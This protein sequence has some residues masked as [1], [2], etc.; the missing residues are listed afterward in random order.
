M[1]KRV[2]TIVPAVLWAAAGLAVGPMS[3]VAMA[4]ADQTANQP[5]NQQAASRTFVEQPGVLEFTG[6]LI[7]R[8]IQGLVAD[9][10]A[11]ARALLAPM[12]LRHHAAVDEYIVRVPLDRVTAGVAGS[13]ENALA[14]E[15]MATGFFQYAVPNWMCYP[16]EVTPN[17]PLFSSQW[18]HQMMR[19]QAGWTISTGSPDLTVAVTDTGI[20]LTHPDLTSHRVLGYDAFNNIAEVNG[21]SVAD[22]HG[23]GTHV[24][25]CAA[26]IGDNG[27]GVA[28]PNWNSKI[29]MIRV[30]INS[31]GGA[32]YEDLMEGAR[33]AIENGAKTVSASYSGVDY[34]PIQT[35]GA[36]IKS[37]GGLYFYAAGNDAR[38]L[39]MFDWPDVTVVGASES[40]DNR[41]GFSA[42]GPG[43]DVFAP[44]QDILSSING[45]AYGWASGT[46]MAT[47]VANGV[48]SLIWSINPAL[49]PDQVQNLL[50]TSSTDKG[51]PGDDDVWGWGRVDVLGA[52]QA[53]AGTLG[54]ADPTASDDSYIAVGDAVAPEAE[55]LDVLSND[56]D[57]NGDAI[58][59]LSF[60]AST[61]AG[62]TLTRSVGTGPGGRDQIAYAA[63]PGYSGA[64][65]FSYTVQDGT[66]RTDTATVT[67][68][69]MDSS[70]FRT[71]ENPIHRAAEINV[72]YY[73]T[74]GFSNLPNFDTMTPYARARSADINYPSTNGAFA[75]SGRSDEVGA[76]FTGFVTVPRT[77]FYT[78]YTSSDDGSRLL[79]GDQVV[80]N[81]DGLHAMEERSGQ[82]GLKAGT[83]AIRVNFFENGGGAGVIASIQGPGLAKQP[84]AASM[85]SRE[86]CGADFNGDGF[87]DF[88]DYDAYVECFEGAACPPRQTADFNGD[89]FADFFDY[90]DFIGAFETG[91]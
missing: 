57:V 50:Y 9:S 16:L 38:N 29:M 73:V 89:G 3:G 6:M 88:F 26:A 75:A 78:F 82:I 55:L 52:T 7:V 41:A 15:L 71:P 58:S 18:H 48:A 65:T 32:Y 51:T 87:V 22:I 56:F 30:A 27:Q 14:A 49:S 36:Y 45:G 44:G 43:V 23:H 85:F 5:A 24:A 12:V 33:W 40:G 13:G 53:A 80:V 83:H 72:A 11:R 90:D 17:D 61:P 4:A 79:I 66:G 25:G 46:S 19:S 84:I 91:C 28:G 67:V 8:P 68:T 42:Y 77:G 70:L 31:G 47:P 21:G 10:D 60:S 62:G 39:N 1:A 35:T 54:P 59:L 20:D 37:I 81:N 63:A 2:C 64:D 74:V 76:V 86:V 69:V 34:E